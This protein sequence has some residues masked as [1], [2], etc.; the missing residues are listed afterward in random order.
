VFH[1]SMHALAELHCHFYNICIYCQYPEDKWSSFARSDYQG[2]A[3][4]QA[5]VSNDLT[6]NRDS[7]DGPLGEVIHAGRYF[8][9]W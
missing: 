6:I 2:S 4:N 9:A 8:F 1:F 7:Y 3:Y 5:T